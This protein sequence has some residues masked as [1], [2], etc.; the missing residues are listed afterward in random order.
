[1]K[2]FTLLF[3]SVII[4]LTI[5]AGKTIAQT[6]EFPIYRDSTKTIE[7]RVQDLLQRMTVEEKVAQVS[8]E[9]FS[10]A[11]NARLGIPKII[12][13]DEQAERKA[14]RHTINFSATINWAATFDAP[15]ILK[16]GVSMGQEVR[17]MGANMLLN[18]CVNILRSP[19]HGRSF[20]ALGEDPWL[21]SRM[22]VAYVKGAQSQKVIACPKHFVANNQDWNRFDVD[23]QVDERTLR[24]IY[25]PAFK[26]TIQEGGA[27]SLM[28]AYNKVRGHWCAES[29]YLLTDVLRHDWGFTGFTVSDWGGTHSTLETARAGLDLEMP[30]GRF[31][32]KD[33]LKAVRNGEIS[34]AIIDQKVGNILR[35][36]FKAG[37][38]DE[39]PAA[40]GGIAN[41]PERRNLARKVA[42]ESIVLLKNENN[43]LPLHR[44]KIKS[45]AVIGPNSNV[46]RVDGGG[47]GEYYGYYQISPLQ[48]IVSKI[49]NDITVQ[50]ERGIPE[51]RLELPI[52][53]SSLYLLPGSEN[54]HGVKAEYFNNR[55]LKG[56]PALVRTEKAIDFDWGYGPIRAGG[57]PGSPAPG[58]IRIDKWSARWTGKLVSP[59]DGLYEI[60]VQ[61]DNGVRLYLDEKLII[62]SWTDSRPSL[63]KIARFKFQ[64]DRRYNFRLEFYE[65][66]GSCQCKL[67]IAPFN[68][69]RT[70]QNAVGLAAKSDVVIL[71]MGLNDEME[72]EAADREQL[73]LPKEQIDLIKAVADVNKNVVVVLN[74]GTPITMSEWIDDIPAL[75]DALYP[76]QEG[77]NALADILFGDVNPSGRL[78]MT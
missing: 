19:F 11:G 17:V 55:E 72:G 44:K 76:G 50:F 28:T 16:V 54:E 31:M 20:E 69:G 60:G 4:I 45:I 65:N 8:G 15:L 67:G 24:E 35:I 39:T 27:W 3:L 1:M 70:K 22:A 23:V 74:N 68:P 12:M 66:W 58:I 49:G 9:G 5:F 56:K 14:K 29:K 64:K 34:E 33:L 18:P 36:M 41:T 21:V 42:Q 52:A 7:Q 6:P 26:A 10:T 38:F 71:C 47:S 43:F 59:G 78:P 51:K 57:G 25:F 32:G 2:K 63:F 37:L 40:Y 75:I 73:V 13:Y 46:A 48:G 77:G 30:E 61:A 53:D 62:D